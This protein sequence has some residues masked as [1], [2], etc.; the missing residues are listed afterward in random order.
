MCRR[1]T[2]LV[3]LL[4]ASALLAQ[5]PADKVI[6]AAEAGTYLNRQVVVEM[7]VR[8]SKDEKPREVFYLDS[9]RDYRDKKNFAVVIAYRDLGAFKKAGV[10]DPSA[11]YKGKKIRVRGKVTFDEKEKQ[12]QLHVQSPAQ[13]QVVEDAPKK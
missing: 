11:F 2:A 10:T 7:L 8:A 6:P 5:P 9:E 12:V 13:I 1:V 4:A 3:P